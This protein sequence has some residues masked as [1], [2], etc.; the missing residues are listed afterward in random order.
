MLKQEKQ[1]IELIGTKMA[2]K[3][4]IK[5][6]LDIV[7]A[8]EWTESYPRGNRICEWCA[9]EKDGWSHDQTEHHENCE[10]VVLVAKAEKWL[11]EN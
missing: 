9:T 2:A 11:E 1:T 4:I 8:A 6:L 5:Q 7:K 3:E 10:F